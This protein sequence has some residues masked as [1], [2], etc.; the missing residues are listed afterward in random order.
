[1]WKPTRTWV[2]A[3]ELGCCLEISHPE[4][5]QRCSAALPAGN[6]SEQWGFPA[7]PSPCMP[8]Q[9]ER[10]RGAPRSEV[11]APRAPSP[12]FCPCAPTAVSQI[13]SRPSGGSGDGA[14]PAGSERRAAPGR[15]ARPRHRARI[16]PSGCDRVCLTGGCPETHQKSGTFRSKGRRGRKSREHLLLPQF[17]L[18][19]QVPGLVGQAF[20]HVHDLAGVTGDCKVEKIGNF[21]ECC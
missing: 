5:F 21:C 12:P 7:P 13:S 16:Q 18:R 8:G 1:M 6:S 11:T 19:L 20:S 4:V 17:P 9:D 10:A 3:P 15:A 14:G 2:I